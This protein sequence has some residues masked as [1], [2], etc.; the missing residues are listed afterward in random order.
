MLNVF[1]DA[2]ADFE[3]D[4]DVKNMQKKPKGLLLQPLE[5]MR[6]TSLPPTARGMETAE[7]HVHPI[8]KA[9][10]P[11]GR[12]KFKLADI[13]H[14]QHTIMNDS[15]LNDTKATHSIL[16]RLPS[17]KAIKKGALGPITKI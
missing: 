2:N 13:D 3:D 1:L 14:G 4:A 16:E 12:G 8:S 9:P 15:S 7:P 11:Q 17:P 6:G 5:K 10:S